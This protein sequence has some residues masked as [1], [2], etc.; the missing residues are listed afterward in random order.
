MKVRLIFVNSLIRMDDEGQALGMAVLN[1][2]SA[3][4]KIYAKQSQYALKSLV[5]H[6]YGH[7]IAHARGWDRKE[8]YHNAAWGRCYAEVYRA[9][10][11]E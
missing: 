8:R 10:M 11:N 2:R 4:I 5:C 7:V 6:E 1:K 3:T 9:M